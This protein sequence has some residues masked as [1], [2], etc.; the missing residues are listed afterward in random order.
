MANSKSP[1]QRTRT[2]KKEESDTTVNTVP[3]QETPVEPVKKV[4]SY[5]VPI[6]LQREPVNKDIPVGDL[7]YHKFSNSFDLNCYRPN[8]EAQLEMIIEGD[9]S[10]TS[11]GNITCISKAESP[12]NWIT[13][14]TNSN[15]FSGNPFIAQ[16]AQEIYE[17]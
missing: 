5:V 15:E 7:Y 2:P 9:I 4:Q 11:S 14:L 13:N 3:E 16:P 8:V 6:L 12:V 1:Q 10:V 17:D